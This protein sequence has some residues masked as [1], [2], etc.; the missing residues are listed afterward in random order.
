MNEQKRLR[1]ACAYTQSEQ[2][3]CLSL[4]YSMN[5]KLLTEHYL[6]LLSLKGGSTSSSESTLVK[7]TYC[8][9]SN[10]AAQL[11]KKSVH[12]MTTE[13]LNKMFERKIE[14]IFL[15]IS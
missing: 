12:N 4:E 6:E 14:N 10:V 9:N 15:S 7:I 5:V 13:I 2:S 11:I 1:P 3:L 8:W